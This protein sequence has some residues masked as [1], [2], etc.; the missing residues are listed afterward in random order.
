MKFNFWSHQTEQKSRRCSPVELWYCVT[1]IPMLLDTRHGKTI[2]SHSSDFQTFKSKD[3][4][5][6]HTDV[7]YCIELQKEKFVVM[8]FFEKKLWSFV[9][10]MSVVKHSN[11]GIFRHRKSRV[12][13]CIWIFDL[14]WK[15][16]WSRTF[17]E[18]RES[19]K[20]LKLKLGSI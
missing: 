12:C 6:F 15:P 1:F 13:F 18:F 2:S 17:S 9:Q 14:N 20:S 4:L 19:D 5:P 8:V 11:Q 10:Y 7:H 3:S 16:K